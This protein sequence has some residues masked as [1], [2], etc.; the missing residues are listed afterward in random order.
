M[1]ASLKSEPGK[2]GLS[3]KAVYFAIGGALVALIVQMIFAGSYIGALHNPSPEGLPFGV[4]APQG[5]GEALVQ[6]IDAAG[7]GALKPTLMA[8]EADL[9]DVIDEVEVYG[10]LVVSADGLRLIVSDAAGS[11]ATSALALFAQGYASAQGVPLIVEHA[12]PLETGD[13]RGLTSTYLVFAWVFGAYFCATVLTTVVGSGY[14]SRRHAAMRIGLL[15]GYAI[16]S[17]LGTALLAS[18]VFNALP[19]HFWDIAAVG[20]LT[21]F[22]VAAATMAV[23]LLLGVVGT[24]I[25]MV[26]VVMIGNP[27]SGGVVLPEFLPAFWKAVGPWLPNSSAYQLLRNMIYFDSAQ[28]TRPIIVLGV[29]ALVGCSLLIIFATR[30]RRS[31]LD[32]P[33]EVELAIG[34]AEA[35]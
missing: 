6:Q 10:G 17:G 2:A 27:S 20:T 21:V 18:Q 13:P 25:A 23:Q 7:A 24:L 8:S 29:Y 11:S 33:P 30:G 9:I 12:H 16:A 32:V 14:L 15:A 26:A 34:A 28:I 3:R 4:V 19:G 35:A 31:P 1:A 5:M 22:A